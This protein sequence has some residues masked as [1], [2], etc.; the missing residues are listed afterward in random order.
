MSADSKPSIEQVWQVFAEIEARENL[1]AWKIGS[2]YL[3]PLLRGMLIRE[4]TEQ[5]WI[6][7]RRPELAKPNFAA[8]ST[9][10]TF[11]P[12]DY[13]VVPFT[14]RNAAGL[15]PFSTFIV[16]SLKA[17][18]H[19]P[20]ILGMGPEDL[21]SGRP[22]VEVLEQEF[23]A[24]YRRIAMLRVAPTLHASHRAKYARVIGF[25][26]TSLAE[27]AA[28]VGIDAKTITGPYRNFP[29]WLLVQFA[30]QRMGWKK[31][32]SSAKVRKVF[33]VNAWKRAL[34]A[35]AQAAG[36]TVVEPQ[37]GAISGIHP[38][39][40][41][42]GQESVAYQPDEFLEWGAYWGDV[43]DLP[44]AT[45]RKVIGAPEFIT[46]A[47]ERAGELAKAG[48]AHQPNTVL[49]AS[50]AHASQAIVEF[51]LQAAAANPD[52]IFTLKQHPQE[53]PADFGPNAPS[54]LILA[55]PNANTL[56]L[57]ARSEVVLGVYTTALFEALA[58]GC[59][60]GVLGFS[61]W[62]H[63]RGLVEHGDAT[64]IESQDELLTFLAASAAGGD[65]AATPVTGDTAPRADYYYAAPASEAELW[66]AIKI[67]E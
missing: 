38:Y 11:V 50:Q 14:R 51:L 4:V 21:G 65:S 30:A 10:A 13:A 33:I 46:E 61:G 32:F 34:I 28:A 45:K 64:L 43:A 31:F 42:A 62:Q 52:R 26:E 56:D 12:A 57:M 3:W 1:V 7:E 29:R 60:V 53:A 23:A 18:G 58:L 49:V 54:N 55:D 66:A 20:L 24:R 39:L 67:A 48:E 36:V 63:I 37:H 15:D 44:R 41:W 40:S 6:F 22:Q 35:G 47:I 5:L 2:I 19:N 16:D 17:H 59:K 9:V 8:G 25:I 27:A